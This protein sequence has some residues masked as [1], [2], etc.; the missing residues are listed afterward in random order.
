MAAQVQLPDHYVSTKRGIV[1]DIAKSFEILGWLAPFILN[2]KI[3]FQHLWKLKLDWDDPLE[4]DLAR[5]HK[6]WRQQ[7]PLLK[8]ITLARCYFQAEETVSVELHGFSDASEAAFAAAVY[9]RAVYSD[10][11]IS[12]KLVIAKTRVA[13]LHTVSMPRLELCGAEMLAEVLATIGNTLQI[14][15]ENFHG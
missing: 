1:S 7:L 6:E 2:M 4:E 10:G 13:P 14:E 5:K 8:S 15:K 9:I 11:S 3:L 12:S